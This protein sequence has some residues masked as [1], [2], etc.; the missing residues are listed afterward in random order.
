MIINYDKKNPVLFSV[1]KKDFD[2]QYFRAGKS[3]GQKG[4]KTSCACR[5][6]HEASGARGESRNHR[7][8]D[9]NRKTAFRRLIATK[10]FKDWMRYQAAVISGKAEAIEKTVDSMMADKHLKVETF[11]HDKWSEHADSIE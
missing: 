9:Q 6:V 10:K 4:D 11:Q 2:I 3:G 7:S 8:Q 1:T 5:L